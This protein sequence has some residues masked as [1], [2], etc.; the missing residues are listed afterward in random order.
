MSFLTPEENRAVNPF[1]QWTDNK[2]YELTV[3]K[4]VVDNFANGKKEFV[5]HCTDLQTTEKFDLK[6]AFD[7][8]RAISAI[9][10][11]YKDASTKLIV[12]S[13][14]DGKTEPNAMG[15]TYDKWKFDVKADG[16]VSGNEPVS[17]EN[18]PF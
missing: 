5:L 14:F 13:H 8:I 11:D 18:V 2:T 7:F 16:Q 15:K 12:T 17:T 9:G 6:F 3:Q 10:D 4:E 1:F